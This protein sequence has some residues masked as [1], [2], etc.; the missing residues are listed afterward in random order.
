MPYSKPTHYQLSYAALELLPSYVKRMKSDERQVEVPLLLAA[1]GW[2]C[3][4]ACA[5]IFKTIYWG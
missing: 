2:G 4:K 5:E 1:S 3:E